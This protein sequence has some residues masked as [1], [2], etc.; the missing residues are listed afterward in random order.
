[1]SGHNLLDVVKIAPAVAKH[2]IVPAEQIARDQL[3]AW[4]AANALMQHNEGGDWDTRRAVQEWRDKH[5]SAYREAMGEIYAQ[6]GTIPRDL[7]STAGKQWKA[8]VGRGPVTTLGVLKKVADTLGFILAPTRYMSDTF[9]E[10]S[11]TEL[12]KQFD[13]LLCGHYLYAI[14]PPSYYSPQRHV[15]S[16]DGYLPIYAG[17][18]ISQAFMAIEMTV[19]LFRTI[20]AEHKELRNHL[21]RTDER[22][23]RMESEISAINRRLARVEEDTNKILKQK[24]TAVETGGRLSSLKTIIA[25]DPLV[26]GLPSDDVSED[27]A[28]CPLGPA[29]GPDFHKGV[30]PALGL[31]CVAGQRKRLERFFQSTYGY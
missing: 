16:E 29:W 1:M 17:K 2:K 5:A 28:L 8:V 10:E 19:P 15:E 12:V 4:R 23:Q 30:L 6:T 25:H 21:Q 13:Q 26:F 20:S 11:P 18:G 7:L 14:A 9:W 24:L 3:Q 31:H 27:E 22:I